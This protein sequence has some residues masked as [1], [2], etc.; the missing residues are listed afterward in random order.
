MSEQA[1]VFV[2]TA[3]LEQRADALQ[4]ALDARGW[5]ASEAIDDMSEAAAANAGQT[6]DFLGSRIGE[7]LGS[8]SSARSP[9]RQ[10]VPTAAAR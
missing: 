3:T 4:T 1:P 10:R 7:A 9:A 2:R 6:A 5:N 8:D